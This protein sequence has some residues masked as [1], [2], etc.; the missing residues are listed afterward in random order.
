MKKIAIINGVNLS[1]LG[2]RE[3]AIYGNTSFDEF[4]PS[5]QNKFPQLH[6]DYFCS[7]SLDEI[8]SF[9]HQ[10]SQYDGIILNPGAYTHTAIVLADAIKSIAV[11]VIEVHISNVMAREPYRKNSMIAAH[12]RGSLSGFGLHGYALALPF[13]A[14][15]VT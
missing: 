3:V 6:I 12:C 13:F 4:L 10:C 9:M 15:E 2:T 5:L 7:N 8:V 1:V 11:P 14:G